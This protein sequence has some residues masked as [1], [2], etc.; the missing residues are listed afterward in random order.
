M[1]AHTHCRLASHLDPADA[2]RTVLV[3]PGRKAR[4]PE[5]HRT[6]AEIGADRRGLVLT[7]TEEAA[8]RAVSRLMGAGR[9]QLANSLSK[10][11]EEL[12]AVS[13]AARVVL[14]GLAN[15]TAF[16]PPDKMDVQDVDWLATASNLGVPVT[17]LIESTQ[18]VTRAAPPKRGRR[19]WW[20]R[21]RESRGNTH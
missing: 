19:G 7:N 9:G 21:R 11:P 13:P 12:F 16:A 15:A 1:A 5:V 10:T 2:W 17:V 6:A 8:L 4:Q 14:M 20:A 3:R 18:P